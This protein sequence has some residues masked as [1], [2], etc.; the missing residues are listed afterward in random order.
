MYLVDDFN[1][2]SVSGTQIPNCSKKPEAEAK[3]IVAVSSSAVLTVDVIVVVRVEVEDS[4]VEVAE[5][6]V[7]EESIAVLTDGLGDAIPSPSPSA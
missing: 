3:V 7:V 2:D 6:V 1:V 5:I 4:D